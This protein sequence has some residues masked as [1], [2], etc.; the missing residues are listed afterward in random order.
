[1]R[2]HLVVR[3]VVELDYRRPEHINNRGVVI[4]EFKPVPHSIEEGL[5][6]A[7]RQII[8]GLEISEERAPAD[9]RLFGNLIDSGL[10]E[11]SLKEEL[12][13]DLAEVTVGGGVHSPGAPGRWLQ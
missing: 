4:G 7:P 12:Q 8:L 2:G 5:K 11:S 13:R 10:L 6:I 9:S 1:M 3:E